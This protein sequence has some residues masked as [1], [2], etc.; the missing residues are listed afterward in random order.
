[1]L[2][3]DSRCFYWVLIVLALSATNG[4][5]F[6]GGGRVEISPYSSKETITVVRVNRQKELARTSMTATFELNGSKET[7]PAVGLEWRKKG[8]TGPKAYI[9]NGETD[10]GPLVVDFSEIEELS[11]LRTESSN[12]KVRALFRVIAFPNVSVE[13][14]VNERPTY[15]EL[16]EKYSKTLELWVVIKNTSGDL[17]FGGKQKALRRVEELTNNVLV[18]FELAGLSRDDTKPEIWKGS[19]EGIWWAIPS[20]IRDPAY[21]YRRPAMAA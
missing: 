14:L 1:M 13:Q 7:F 4:L 6:D 5:S 17:C 10:S 12:S 8:R 16:K 15:T 2:K 19:G 3:P 11:I 21:P 9:L 20:V 18:K